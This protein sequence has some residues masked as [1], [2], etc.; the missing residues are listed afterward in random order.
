MTIFP[1]NVLHNAV[2]EA[3][4]ATNAFDRNER[5]DTRVKCLFPTVLVKYDARFPP[6]MHY[7]PQGERPISLIACNFWEGAFLEV[8]V[9]RLTATIPFTSQRDPME[10]SNHV[11]SFM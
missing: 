2:I 10:V 6:V 7:N 8:G 3:R 9:I 1:G 4:I 5:L 11:Q